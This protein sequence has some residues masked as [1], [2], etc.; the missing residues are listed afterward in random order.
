MKK[1]LFFLILVFIFACQEKKSS[2]QMA[3]TPL[4]TR[5]AVD[6]SPENAWPEYPR[7]QMERT[8]WM[9]LNGLW[10]FAITPKGTEPT[11]FTQQILVPYP[12]ESALS[13]IGELILPG[14][15]NTI[16]VSVW[17]PTSDSYQ[18]R[19]KQVNEPEGIFYTP[20]TGIWQSV[21]LEPLNETYIEDFRIETDLDS[22]QI[23]IL[24]DV[25]NPM[26]D[27]RIHVSVGDSIHSYGNSG[28]WIILAIQ[29]ARLWQPADPFLYPIKLRVVRNDKAVDY[30]ETYSGFRKISLGQDEKCITRLFLNNEPVFQSGPLDQGFWPD[31]IYTPPTDE[32][33]RYDLEILK[34]MGFNMLR[35]HV[36]VENQRFYTWCDRLGML[37]WQDRGVG[38]VFD[39]HHY[40]E[41]RMPALEP[42]RASVLG[43]F[44]GLGYYVEGHTWQKENWGYQKITDQLLLSDRFSEFYDSVRVFRDHGMS[45]AVYTQ[46]TDVETECN[47]LMTYDREVI[48]IDTVILKHIH[49]SLTK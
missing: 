29:D 10:D 1:V 43:E 6:V 21:W 36:K 20:A 28:E 27:D 18:P 37:V 44:G 23:R 38:D 48:K 9:N 5:W 2:W 14:A 39:I 31:G 42:G 34:A 7:P 15:K 22:S 49:H 46:I 13:G 19:G 30:I 11:S 41:P 24:V 32:A 17:D 33:M 8:E 4:K 35:K 25:V 16:R 12:V 3:S 47:G 26:P 45:A 40:P